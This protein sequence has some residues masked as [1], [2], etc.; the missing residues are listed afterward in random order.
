M[1]YSIK[2]A[3]THDNADRPGTNEGGTV[4]FYG[5]IWHLAEGIQENHKN[6]SQNKQFSGIQTGDFLNTKQEC[7]PLHYGDD[8][9]LFIRLCNISAY[10][11]SM[12]G[13]YAKLLIQTSTFYHTT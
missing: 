5:I 4:F 9:R 12:D 6:L 2:W 8:F 7:S 10:K 13:G 11:T 3:T 1:L